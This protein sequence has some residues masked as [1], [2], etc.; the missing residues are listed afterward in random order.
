MRINLRDPHHVPTIQPTLQRRQRAPVAKWSSGRCCISAK[1]MTASAR[2]GRRVVLAS[3]SVNQ[4]M[5]PNNAPREPARQIVFQ[6]LRKA[7]PVIKGP[8]SQMLLISSSI[9][10]RPLSSQE[11]YS[12]SAFGAHS[13]SRNVPTLDPPARL[14]IGNRLRQDGGPAAGPDSGGPARL[15]FRFLQ[16]PRHAKASDRLR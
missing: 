10:W 16:M 1:S 5:L 8:C 14:K 6:P 9:R 12:C 2:Q 3:D 13:I 7:R 15:S 11:A 4:P